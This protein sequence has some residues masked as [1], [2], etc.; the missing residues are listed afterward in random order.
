MTLKAQN[1]YLF[2]A[3]YN[4]GFEYLQDLE[5]TSIQNPDKNSYYDI[6]YSPH[7]PL[8]TLYQFGLVPAD[9]SPDKPEYWIDFRDG[10]FIANGAK[11]FPYPRMI[12]NPSN[13]R[14]EALQL[15][16]PRL[17]YFR[18]NN[19]SISVDQETGQMTATGLEVAGYI[20]GY[21]CNNQFGDNHEFIM[22][23]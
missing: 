19:A 4:D 1:T 13:D 22:R 3:R 5:D 7:K 11:F 10:S 21:Q 18:V 14:E 23:I 15:S 16:N 2:I 17:I 20:L 6:F 12:R 9:G 8:E